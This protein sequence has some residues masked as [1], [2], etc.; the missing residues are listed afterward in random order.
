[1]AGDKQGQAILDEK[2]LKEYNQMRCADLIWDYKTTVL[3]LAG[4]AQ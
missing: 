1:M 2:K 3:D 4:V